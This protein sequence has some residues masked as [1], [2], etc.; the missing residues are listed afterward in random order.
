MYR[1]LFTRSPSVPFIHTVSLIYPRD[2]ECRL[3]LGALCVALATFQPAGYCLPFVSV[4]SSLLAFNGNGKQSVERV[5]F[6][7]LF[8][9]CSS[10][11]GRVQ[12]LDFKG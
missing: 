7:L 11:R 3:F 10:R 1:G 8:G 6:G 12:E 2:G 9:I 5:V 4:A